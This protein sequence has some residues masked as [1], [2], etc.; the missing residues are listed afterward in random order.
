MR[1]LLCVLGV[2]VVLLVSSEKA[3]AGHALTLEAAVARVAGEGREVRIAGAAH[4]SARAQVLAERAAFFPQVSAG[5]SRHYYAYQPA[6]LASGTKILTAER[7][8][9]AYGVDVH[10]VLFDFGATQARYKAAQFAAEGARDEVARSRNKAVLAVITAY[11]DVLEAERMIVVAREQLASL[12]RH[13]RDVTVLY[14]EGVV[15]RGDLLTVKVRFNE[16]RQGLVGARNAHRTASA[17][18]RQALSSHDGE[19]FILE[20]PRPPACPVFDLKRAFEFALLRRPELRAMDKAVRA[21]EWREEFSKAADRPVFFVDGAYTRADNRYQARDD[22]WQGQAGVKL[23]IFNGGLTRARAESAR[24]EKERAR[25]E[26]ARLED[27]VRCETETAM[28]A[29]G[30]AGERVAL[31][32]SSVAQAQENVR[33]TETRYH[34][35]AGT[36]SE[37]LDA[38]ALRTGAETELWR[39]RYEFRRARARFMDATGMDLAQEYS[40]REDVYGQ[41]E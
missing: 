11:F 9:N 1:H 26:R 35:G 41:S 28:V 7:S 25:L 34:E 29:M 13:A 30:N 24:Q 4:L 38:L 8:F 17:R 2:L 36:S 3:W 33:V 21:A 10:Q 39:A 31:A 37:V 14:R 16:A 6:S 12:A 27:Q 20:D 32:R 22:N 40:D 5:A 15:T 23:S 19:A 18:L